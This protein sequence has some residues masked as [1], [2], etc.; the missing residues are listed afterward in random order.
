MPTEKPIKAKDGKLK[1]WEP[2]DELPNQQDIDDLYRIVGK[3]AFELQS[4]GIQWQ[5]EEI[6][7]LINKTY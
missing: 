2:T 6:L 1:Q 3:M 4:I 7:N 5:D